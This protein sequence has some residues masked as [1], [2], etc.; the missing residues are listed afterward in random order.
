M[1]Q[2]L[3]EDLIK[4]LSAWLIMA[5]ILSLMPMGTSPGFQDPGAASPAA[6]TITANKS[7]QLLVD[8]NRTARPIL[9]T[10]CAIR[11]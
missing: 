11:W 5:L 9:A 6:V 3:T 10:R 1:N 4:P 8:G 2:R 7:D